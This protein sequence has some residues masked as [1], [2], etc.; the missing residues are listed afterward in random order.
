MTATVAQPA[1]P[2][3]ALA[4]D[5]PAGLPPGL[6]RRDAAS[7]IAVPLV[8]GI[9]QSMLFAILPSVARDH[10]IGETGV[11]LI[12]MLPAVVWALITIWWGRRCDVWDRK[13]ILLLSILGFAASM[14][15]FA[16]A[17]ALAY[18]GLIGAGALWVLIL[19]SRLMYS[20]MSSGALPA[21]QAYVVAR[22]VPRHR[23]TAI[24]RISAAWNFGTLLG[25]GIIGLLAVF[26]VLTP[27]IAAGIIAL[28]VWAVVRVALSPQPPQPAPSGAR[29]RLRFA[30]PRIRM[31]L[32]T[33]LC[34]SMAQAILLQTLGFFFM[35]GLGVASGDV[36]R[37]VG[38]ALTTAGL[39]TLLSQVVLVPLMGRS[40]AF[41]ERLGAGVTL[42]AFL[43]LAMADSIMVAWLATALSGLGYG[44]LRPGN[45]AH[46][47]QA[48]QAHEQGSVAGLNGALWS[49]GYIITPLFTMPLHGI[50]PQ[51]PFYAGAVTLLLAIGFSLAAAPKRR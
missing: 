10:G 14:L 30:D 38:V 2:A 18:L 13:P 6:P 23:T 3:T 46:A 4:P 7:L 26:G 49:A 19:V 5:T 24:G 20:T 39:A 32:V 33:G 31:I 9:G 29:R 16:G 28:M 11:A 37:T 21:A 1:P 35:D 41:M 17:A 42:G 44:L 50:D 45:I 40:P 27:M 34:G 51:L 36:P 12:Y 47:S 43:I 8:H 25:P 48:V 22:T 15:T